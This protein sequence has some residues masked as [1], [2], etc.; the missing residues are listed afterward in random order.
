[1]KIEF[2]IKNEIIDKSDFSQKEI[3]LREL[4]FNIAKYAHSL[5]CSYTSTFSF[6]PMSPNG[7]VIVNNFKHNEI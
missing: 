3:H 1:M 4:W 6:G 5:E 2:E 7:G